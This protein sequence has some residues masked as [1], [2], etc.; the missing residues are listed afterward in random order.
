[1]ATEMQLTTVMGSTTFVVLSTDEVAWGTQATCCHAHFGL[2]S[3]PHHRDF[4]PGKVGV[5]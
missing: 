3:A 2:K 4:R 5:N 1:M